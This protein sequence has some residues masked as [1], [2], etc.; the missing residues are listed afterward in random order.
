MRRLLDHLVVVAASITVWANLA[1]AQE[2][3]PDAEKPAPIK[4]PE[5]N[6]V[7]ETGDALDILFEKLSQDANPASAK[8]TAG[9]IWRRWTDSG[10]D[11]INLLMQWTSSAL[12]TSDYP[13]ALDLLTNVTVLAPDYAEGWNRRALVYFQ[14]GELGKSIS[15][16]QTVLTLEP[17]HFGALSGLAVI[18]QRVGREK[19][20]LETWYKVLAVYPANQQA[21]KSVIDL[22]E[23]LAGRQI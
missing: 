22:E 20:A 18:L 12:E 5:N 10:S 3:D 1:F 15:D 11:N 8:A 19:D 7:V 13:Q 4:P 9:M 21:Q 14:L 16:I 17:R 2:I 23:E 6:S